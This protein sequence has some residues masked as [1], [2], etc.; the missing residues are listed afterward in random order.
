MDSIQA[1]QILQTLLDGIDPITRKPLPDD[2]PVLRNPVYIA[3]DQAIQCLKEDAPNPPAKPPARRFPIRPTQRAT[4][5]WADWS[6]AEQ[7]RLIELF[8]AGTTLP[9]LARILSRSEVAVRTRLIG[10]GRM[11]SHSSRRKSAAHRKCSAT[12]SPPTPPS[13][14]WWKKARPQAG[15]PWTPEERARLR[16]LAS[17][18]MSEAEMGRHLGRGELSIGVQLMKLGIRMR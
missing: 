5:N 9:E 8:D 4:G 3:L 17:T 14:K 16:D 11:R 13:L 7:H 6:Q 15:K 18:G 2:S 10:L 1:R 12:P